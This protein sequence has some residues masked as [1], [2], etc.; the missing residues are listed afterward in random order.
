MALIPPPNWEYPIASLRYPGDDNVGLRWERPPSRKHVPD[1][2]PPDR[3]PLICVL[4]SSGFRGSWQAGMSEVLE[5]LAHP[6]RWDLA[7]GGTI[8]GLACAAGIGHYWRRIMNAGAPTHNALQPAAGLR[9][10]ERKNL[11][12][13]GVYNLSELEGWPG[14]WLAWAGVFTFRDLR[15]QPHEPRP[16][17]VVHRAGIGVVVWRTMRPYP[18]RCTPDQ[19]SDP[20][21]IHRAF[22]WAFFGSQFP[23]KQFRQ[24]WIPDTVGEHLPWLADEIDDHSPAWWARVSMSQWPACLPTVM[25]DPR[26]LQLVFLA[27]GGHIDNQPSLFNDG[28][29][30]SLPLVNPRL[31]QNR[32]QLRRAQQ[33]RDGR[34]MPFGRVIRW[35]TTTQTRWRLSQ[36]R[37]ITWADRDAMYLCGVRQG[38]AR[39]GG[40]LEELLNNYV[41]AEHETTLGLR[42]RAVEI[43][44]F[45]GFQAIAAATRPGTKKVFG[46]RS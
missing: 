42:E 40:E 4:G 6:V 28:R 9:W 15:Y 46:L 39:L 23:F 19:L 3:P 8:P 13:S 2:L 35:E 24:A 25:Q 1:V 22:R 16:A 38:R 32:R 31:A 14:A 41:G 30:T 33:V 29:P 7:S 5:Q 11:D 36:G 37:H 34:R 27:D 10:F 20:S 17:G 21:F 12:L 18:N 43:P 26:T 44:M 45:H